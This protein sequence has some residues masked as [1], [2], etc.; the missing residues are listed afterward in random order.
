MKK[1]NKK[2]LILGSSGS[3]GRDLYELL[4]PDFNVIGTYLNK[5]HSKFGDYRLDLLNIYSFKKIIKK[6]QPDFVINTTG[7]ASPEE[8]EQN[9]K[10]SYL[11]N[12]KAAENVSMIC[13]KEKIPFIY[14]STDYI[15]Q[16]NKKNYLED[17]IPCPVNYYG[18]TKLLGETV[19]KDGIILRLP[20]V[21]LLNKFRDS[22]F[23]GIIKK[24]KLKIDNFRI[25][26]FLWTYDLCKVIERM[27]ELNIDN[28]VYHVC[29]D[30]LFTKYKLAELFLDIKKIDKKI[31]SIKDKES[32]LRPRR[33]IMRNKKVKKLG[34]RFTPLKKVFQSER[35][36]I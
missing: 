34:I 10:G 5:K 19:S 17:D 12:Y 9:K 4:K 8:C 22:F 14:F 21:I 13:V 16:G 3:I 1:K 31:I 29:G 28:G 30:E 36:N 27:I 23:Q 15:F 24:N 18:I 35:F 25:R 6:T 20:K 7:I 26:K 32:A 33:S 2:I 11:I